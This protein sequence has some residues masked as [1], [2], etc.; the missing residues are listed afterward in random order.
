MTTLE[1]TNA[2]NTLDL[3]FRMIDN[4]TQYSFHSSLNRD[5]NKAIPTLTPAQAKEVYDAMQDWR[6]QYEHGQM[7]LAIIATEPTEPAPTQA[8][9]SEKKV[10]L[11][12]NAWSM[13]KDGLFTSFAAALKAA[14]SRLKVVSGMKSG[15]VSFE[16]VKS[17]GTIRLAKGTLTGFDYTAKT[18]ESKPKPEV[19]KYFD[20]EAQSF[21]SFR[22]DRF[23][24]LVA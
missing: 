2:I 15:V 24:G 5:I 1:I 6:K 9:K 21:R 17:D 22:I 20:I 19:I 23:L 11:F 4:H 8:A 16:Y 10:S 14:W 7:L 18:T 13:F 12:N 3:D